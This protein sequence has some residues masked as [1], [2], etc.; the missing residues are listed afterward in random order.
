[1]TTQALGLQRKIQNQRHSG[2]NLPFLPALHN[3]VFNHTECERQER[4]QMCWGAH[5]CAGTSLSSY[6][7]G[8]LLASHSSTLGASPGLSGEL[9]QFGRLHPLCASVRQATVSYLTY[10][11]VAI[12]GTF[13]NSGNSLG[14][15]C[16]LGWD[17]SQFCLAFWLTAKHSLPSYLFFKARPKKP[18]SAWYFVDGIDK[19]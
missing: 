4:Q 2:P 9:V 14:C 5:W 17:G 8:S 13:W 10:P 15:C 3:L 12:L 16:E 7:W 19:I 18:D 1:M 6:V 11:V